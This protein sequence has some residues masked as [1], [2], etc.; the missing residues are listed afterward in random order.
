M[1]MREITMENNIFSKIKKNA[2]VLTAICGLALL[3]LYVVGQFT[4]LHP[5]AYRDLVRSILV[6]Y[7]I[8]LLGYGLYNGVYK[9]LPLAKVKSKKSVK[10]ESLTSITAKK[11]TP[12]EAICVTFMVITLLNSIMMLT[13]LDTPKA[14]TFAYIHMMTRLFIITGIILIFMW[15]D[16]VAG[17]KKF[18]FNHRVKYFYREAHKSI[19]KSSAK[20]FTFI[21]AVYCL[22]MIV[23]QRVINPGGGNFFYQSLLGIL[24]LTVAAMFVLRL[25]RIRS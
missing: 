21:T 3:F 6:G 16:V 14:G 5:D 17:L 2:M 8:Y 9:K 24:V 15:K 12:L 13:G 22:L 19:L 10:V 25:S 4:E 18:S 7:G 1:N 20:I 23:F 11:E